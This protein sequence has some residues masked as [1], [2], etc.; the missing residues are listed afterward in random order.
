RLARPNKEQRVIARRIA[1]LQYAVY[2]PSDADGS[3]PPWIAYDDSMLELPHAAWLHEAIRAE[4]TVPGLV[5]NDADVALC[6]IEAGLGKSLLPAAIGDSTPGLSRLS[7]EEA[8]LEREVWLLVLPEL[9][10]LSR[11][12]AVI[13]WLEKVFKGPAHG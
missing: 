1:Q 2:G 9:K 8:I 5:V 6:A 11:I 12:K 3:V 4:G 7:G 10:H 13:A